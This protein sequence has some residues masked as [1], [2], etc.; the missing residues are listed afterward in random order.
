[1][2]AIQLTSPGEPLELREVTSPTPDGDD[3]VVA[4]RA[5]GICRS[6]LHYRSGFPQ[7]GPLPLTLG[8]EV[9][10]V[11]AAAGEA[12]SDY[13]VGDR[14]C[15]HYQVGCGRCDY[16]DRGFEQFCSEGKM[17]GNGRPGG[18]AEQ[19]VVPARNVI[20][21]PES[22]PLSHAAVMMCSSATSLHA[23]RKARITPGE[24]VAIFGA[25]GL[26][27]SAIQLALILGADRVFA[28]DVNPTTVDR[29]IEYDY[30]PL[31]RLISTTYTTGQLYSYE[32]APVG[33]RLAHRE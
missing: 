14:V 13:S 17:I 24:S 33:N 10:G 32:Y 20:P 29:V 8:H 22:V 9:A 11:V 2:R 15:I 26:G 5:T 31:S 21:V 12:V 4:V 28:V 27:V 18:Y 25:G 30:D 3:V 6:D 7:V 19:I 16:C 23:L 1:M